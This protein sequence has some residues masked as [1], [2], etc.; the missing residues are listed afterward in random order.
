MTTEQGA[1]GA[2]LY[3]PLGA[4]AAWL[5]R[6]PR[7]AVRPVAW[8]ELAGYG[9]LLLAAIVMRVWDLGARKRLATCDEVAWL[10]SF[11]CSPA[12][13]YITGQTLT[14][15]G[16]KT[17][18]GDWWPIPD[19]PDVGQVEIPREPWEEDSEG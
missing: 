7:S 1:K 17:L 15:D 13:A 9:S 18:W 5:R 3:G 11:L 8:W 19:P 6:V 16:G 12:G 10:V 2:G 4:A 14:L